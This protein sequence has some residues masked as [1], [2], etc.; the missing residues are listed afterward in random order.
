MTSSLIIATNFQSS[1]NLLPS[2]IFT[3]K[4]PCAVDLTMVA[5]CALL[6]SSS[7]LYLCHNSGRFLGRF[8]YP[9]KISENLWLSDVFKSYR[10]RLV[11]LNVSTRR[12]ILKSI[13]NL[14]QENTITITEVTIYRISMPKCDFNKVALQHLWRDASVTCHFIGIISI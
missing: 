5:L 10:E 13:L 12:S 2:W 1:L 9:L 6:L 14:L 7:V 11:S 4:S 3:K 8:L